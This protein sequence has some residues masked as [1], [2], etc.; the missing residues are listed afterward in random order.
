MQHK[1]GCFEMFVS[2][3]GG[4]VVEPRREEGARKENR[5]ANRDFLTLMMMT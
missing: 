5:D 1:A 4:E 2:G 3:Q